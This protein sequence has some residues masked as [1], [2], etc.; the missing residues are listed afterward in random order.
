MLFHTWTFAVFFA[1]VY[2]VYRLTKGTRLELPWLLAASYVFY[3][4]WN[5][6][7]LI[8]IAYGTIV[9]YWIVV[10]MERSTR[11][12][13]WIA[14]SIVSNLG[15]LGFFKYAGFVAT[16]LNWLLAHLGLRC[17]IPAPD[18]LL[19]VGISF[20]TF[21]SM[22]YILDCYRGHVERERSFLRYAVYV[23]LFTQLVAG[24]IE[25]AS[26]LLRQLREE[27][28]VT[29]EDITDGLSL[30][31]AGLFKK[32]ALA[33]YLALYVDKVYG[34]PGTFQAP[35]LALAT[36]AFAWQIYFDFSGYTDMARGIARTMGLRLLL[37]FSHPYLADSLGDFWQRWHISLSTWFRDYVYIPLGGNRGGAL[38]TYRN[39]VLTMVISGLWHGAAW[40]FLIWGVLHALGR[41]LTR[42]LERSRFY[43]E[44]V[45][46]PLKQLGVFAFVTFA[47]IFF[48]APSLG[49]AWLI[50][51]RIATS[52]W[53]DPAFP[54]LALG[55]A[56]SVWVYQFLCESKARA[57]LEWAPVRVSMAVVLI[58]YLAT[59]PAGA[60]QKFIYFQ[61]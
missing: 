14:L 41:V 23:S 45:P 15:L 13:R 61:F 20:F 56:L 33:D 40:T 60:A 32:V 44:R 51:S 8:L 16:N 4:W 38:A 42:E 25:R 43:R 46:R 6:L 17:A 54:L 7:Y 53:A 26:N 52:G 29:R 49:D 21:Q 31:V 47:W 27:H 19:P 11:K 5:P 39:M 22:S 2:P 58:V 57:M 30:F 48:R 24:P 37:N 55:L 1:I 36:F 28:R 10:R 18:I 3:G 34:A 12:K 35:A 9:D 50:V 59:F